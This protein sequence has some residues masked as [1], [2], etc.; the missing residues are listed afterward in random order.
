MCGCGAVES[1]ET[2]LGQEQVEASKPQKSTPKVSRG[3]IAPTMS[4]VCETLAHVI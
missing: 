4:Q 3:S 1:C 2:D